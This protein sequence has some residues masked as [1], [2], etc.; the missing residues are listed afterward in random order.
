MG[1]W[2]EI[3]HDFSFC[4]QLQPPFAA[5]IGF[6]IQGLRDRCRATYC[7]EPEDFD[8]KVRAFGLD[9]EQI[10]YVDLA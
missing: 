9:V 1:R 3:P 4:R 10:A 6:T 8:L 5:G 7:T 2:I